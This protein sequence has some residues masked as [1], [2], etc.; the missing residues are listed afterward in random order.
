MGVS[1]PAD[2][3]LNVCCPSNVRASITWTWDTCSVNASRSMAPACVNFTHLA[4]PFVIEG[5]N[6]SSISFP[7][8]FL[9]Y[10]LILTW[11]L[12]NL[13]R[14]SECRISHTCTDPSWL[15]TANLSDVWFHA[16][17]KLASFETIKCWFSFFNMQVFFFFPYLPLFALIRNS[18]N[19]KYWIITPDYRLRQ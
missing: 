11:T 10:S 15:D 14:G 7:S 17:E 18:Q 12:V 1:C 2:P 9:F 4:A 13:A 8:F 5:Y 19:R 16:I 6:I 3:T